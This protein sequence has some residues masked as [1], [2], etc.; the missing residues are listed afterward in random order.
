MRTECPKCSA[1][2]AWYHR[3]G[4]DLWLRCLCG[5]LKVV[6]TTL[7][8]VVIL[9]GTA[10]EHVKLPKRETNLWFTLMVTAAL[11]LANSGEITRRLTD[12]GKSF[13]V[14]DVASYLTIMRGKGLV[15]NTEVR[16]GVVGGSTWKV[17]DRAAE[18]MGVA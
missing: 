4:P 6:E 10:P 16:R 3:D 9:R 15:E 7:E 17:S 11:E 12:L 8:E 18:L 2:S 5:Y 1:E 13:S 14:S